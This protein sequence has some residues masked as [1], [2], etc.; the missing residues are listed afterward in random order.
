MLETRPLSPADVDLVCHHRT[1][2]FRDMGRDERLVAE[3]MGP[4]RA[5]LESRL[6]DG[7]YFGFV[8]EDRSVPVAGLGLLV[9]EWP[10]ALAHPASDRRGYILDVYVEPTH[11][12]RGIARTLV[13]DALAEFRRRDITYVSLHASDFGR[14]LYESLGFTAT[15]EMGMS[16]G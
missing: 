2:M 10:P 14:P 8:V 11:R 6:G 13:L 7:T 4:F 9:N 15:T 1:A 5:W 3:M 16:L 12:R